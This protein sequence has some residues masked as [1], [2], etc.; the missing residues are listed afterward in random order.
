M[1]DIFKRLPNSKDA[2][3]YLKNTGD[4]LIRE[5]TAVGALTLSVKNR[6]GVSHYRFAYL[7]KEMT[8]CGTP[9][10]DFYA[11]NQ[12]KV[13]DPEWVFVNQYKPSEVQRMITSSNGLI[14]SADLNDLQAV[15]DLF[16]SVQET[17][18]LKP[19]QQVKP[20]PELQT[21]I[22]AYSRYKNDEVWQEEEIQA[23]PLSNNAI[24]HN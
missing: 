17:L 20:L 7:P 10:E 4:W 9:Y 18:G 8:T 24:A 5:S 1:P 16:R 11:Q 12:S 15:R 19:S 14:M 13:V 6:D 3:D 22:E 21:T 2:K 23:Q